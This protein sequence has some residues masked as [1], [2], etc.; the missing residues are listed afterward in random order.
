MR[1]L[2][3]ASVVITGASSGIGR[4][5]A[6]A[7]ARRGACV[8]LAARREG[9]LREAATACEAEGGKALAVT[10]DVGDP[11][12][13][14]QLAHSAIDTFGKIDVWVNNAGVGAV[15]AF[16]DTPIETHDQVVRT[17]LLGYVHGAHAVLP[18]FVE[19]GGG[20]LINNLS[21]GAWVPAPFAAAYSASKFGLRGFTDALRAE[22]AFAPG[23]DICDIYPSF[24]DTPG[25]QHGANYTGRAL[26]PAPP[27]YAPRRVGAAMV[28]LALRPRRSVTVGSVAS[29]ARLGYFVAPRLM[30]STMSAVMKAYLAQASPSPIT[31]GNVLQPMAEG[32]NVEG[33]WR[34]PAE[35]SLVFASLAVAAGLA[36]LLLVPRAARGTRQ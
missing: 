6:I 17:N 36:A 5:A 30:R 23:I 24:I 22:F 15:G 28:A 20:V 19:R 26:K 25:I 14:R 18:H 13:V 16:L 33:G 12:A 1:E 27:V 29:L 7:F 32:R 10:T 4:A 2:R 8:T 21:F 34:S 3:G 11:E 9:V 31:D 35:R